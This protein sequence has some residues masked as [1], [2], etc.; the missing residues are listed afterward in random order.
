M[1]MNTGIYL[2]I[3][4]DI[5]R[6]ASPKSNTQ[7]VSKHNVYEYEQ[8]IKKT[9]RPRLWFYL[10]RQ[11]NTG[12]HK[13]LNLMAQFET[14]METLSHELKYKMVMILVELTGQQIKVLLENKDTLRKLHS[15]NIV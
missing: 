12:R 11:S 14:Y 6:I 13:S 4:E 7:S 3:A 5:V 15:L 2:P 8:K 9:I 1:N 10:F